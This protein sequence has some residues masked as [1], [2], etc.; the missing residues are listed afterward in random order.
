MKSIILRVFFLLALLPL[1]I[2]ADIK[3]DMASADLSLIQ[4]VENAL[5]EGQ[6]IEDIVAQ[7]I[8][9]DPSQAQSIVATAILYRP[10]AVE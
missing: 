1:S 10:N 8:A 7:M 3:A 4:V 9:I 6:S 2:Q 5:K